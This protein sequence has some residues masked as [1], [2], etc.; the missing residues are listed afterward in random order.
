[1]PC[2]TYRIPIFKPF[3]Q[4]YLLKKQL[5]RAKL[6]SGINLL[7]QE[8]LDWHWQH[9][10]GLLS[11]VEKGYSEAR[12]AEAADFSF[13]ANEDDPNV[14]GEQPKWR[15]DK[16][17]IPDSDDSSKTDESTG[18]MPSGWRMERL[19][20]YAPA[21]FNNEGEY[22]IHLTIEGI[23][24]LARTVHQGC[25]EQELKIMRLAAAY[26][27][28]AHELCH[29]WIEDICCLIDFAAGFG[30][31][32]D[33][34]RYAKTQKRYHGYIFMEE[35]ICNTAAYGWLHH[36]LGEGQPGTAASEPDFNASEIL[37][38]FAQWMRNQPKG[39][40]EFLVIE[41][42]PHQNDLFIR[43]VWRLLVEVYRYP[44][45]EARQALEAYFNGHFSLPDHH[46]ESETDRH[47]WD[48]YSLWGG[49]PPMYL[50]CKMRI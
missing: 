9:R 32:S 25:S 23:A 16:P 43:N 3:A 21:H 33:Q 41:Q 26:K 49:E 2:G 28:Y 12:L 8:K 27:L 7:I 30:S 44:E 34:S 42:L 50:D 39:Y 19:A 36:F 24:K 17:D 29:A 38:A 14:I 1:M 18:E 35:A 13:Y 48:E 10:E 31:P 5:I 46:W 20:F 6:P 4:K 37:N 11:Q 15:M 40:R 47:C 22:G 45:Y